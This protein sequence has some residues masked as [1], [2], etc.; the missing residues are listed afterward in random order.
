MSAE[1]PEVR[2]QD[3]ALCPSFPASIFFEEYESDARTAKLADEICASCP[4]K[5]Q[6]LQWGIEHNEWGCW[7]GV[8][9]VNGKPDATKNAHK[10]PEQLK[11][12][13]ALALD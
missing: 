11:E 9:L 13:K 3:F 4:V 1:N 12:I 5:M 8:F 2:W 6:C 7:G 10:T